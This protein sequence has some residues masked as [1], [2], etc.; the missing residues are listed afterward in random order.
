MHSGRCTAYISTLQSLQLNALKLSSNSEICDVQHIKF[1]SDIWNHDNWIGKKHPWKIVF[2][3]H[4]VVQRDIL[5]WWEKRARYGDISF[6]KEKFFGSET[7]WWQWWQNKN[8]NSHPSSLSNTSLLNFS[9]T[10]AL[11][12]LCLF[13]PKALVSN[14][15]LSNCTHGLIHNFSLWIVTHIVWV[16]LSCIGYDSNSHP[17]LF[18]CTEE[19][20]LGLSPSMN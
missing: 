7:S 11:I 8:N 6:G 14:K 15:D 20:T 17:T 3:Y 1:I 2:E 5:Q 9:V 4:C 13:A 16:A 12:L 19:E 18:V 10:N